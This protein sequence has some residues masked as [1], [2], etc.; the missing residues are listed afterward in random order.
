MVLC[1]RD[2]RKFN[3][4]CPV[5]YRQTCFK[6]QQFVDKKAVQLSTAGRISA[7]PL[8]CLAHDTN[9]REGVLQANFELRNK[10]LHGQ[11][12]LI[13]Y[14]IPSISIRKLLLL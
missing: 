1:S 5:K 8:P 11:P 9:Y 6:R 10:S 14:S 4:K 2:F 3:V 12:T 13:R 7:C